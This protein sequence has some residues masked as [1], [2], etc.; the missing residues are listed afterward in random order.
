LP[1]G[2]FGSEAALFAGG[3]SADLTTALARTS[4][5]FVI[6]HS[7]ALTYQGRAVSPAQI[8]RELGV[9][10]LVEG[11]VRRAGNRVRVTAELVEAASGRHVW[12]ETFDRKLD[13]LFA[14]QAEIAEKILGGVGASVSAA[15]LERIRRKPTTS[16][17]AYEAQ[18]RGFQR[19]GRFRREDTREAQRLLERAIEL[20]PNY[21]LA[22]TYLG[23]TQAAAYA[24]LQT[25]DSSVLDRADQRFARAI[26]LDP[27]L[28][29]PHIAR[30][31]GELLRGRPEQ[32]RIWMERA[33]ELAPSDPGPHV[34]LAL[35]YLQSGDLDGAWAS[36]ERGRRLNPRV[37][38]TNLYKAAQTLAA[39]EMSRGKPRAAEALWEQLR[40]EFP[41]LIF[42]RLE[43]AARYQRTHREPQ[44]RVVLAEALAV[45]PQLTTAALRQHGL[46][47][48]RRDLDALLA[49]LRAAGLP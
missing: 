39:L 27:Q 26:E 21:A 33:R 12:S 47:S 10:Y 37:P 44:A 2:A 35:L 23:V 15:E 18:V 3:V 38:A 34:F 32:A 11:A 9:Q 24:E 22:I 13:D 17:S 1:F 41:E 20:D 28:P 29:F 45:N 16:L 48:R 31:A 19:F 5:L 8:G 7:S 6:S 49:S 30:G 42:P 36:F 25:L 40:S 43:L 4:T 46:F 14:V